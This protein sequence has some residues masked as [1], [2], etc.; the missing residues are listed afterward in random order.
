M[1]RTSPIVLALSVLALVLGAL[2][3]QA[4]VR[5]PM[6]RILAASAPDG[7]EMQGPAPDTLRGGPAFGDKE[8]AIGRPGGSNPASPARP[9]LVRPAAPLSP[10]KPATTPANPGTKTGTKTPGTKTASMPPPIAF[11]LARGE[12][13][14]CGPGCSEWIGAD[15]A[16]DASAASRLR[17]LLNR[18]G[19]HRLP[20]FF[21]SPGGS[22]EGSLAIGRLMRARG[23]TAGVA[24]TVPQGCDPKQVREEACDRLKRSG[25]DLPAQLDTATTMC[26]SA[27]VYAIVGAAVRTIGPGAKLGIHSSSFTFAGSG[28]HASTKLPRH[29]MRA[30]IEASYERLGRYF[31]EMGIDPALVAAAREIANDHIRVLSRTDIWR[32]KID[33]RGFIE[34]GWR[35]SNPPARAIHKSFVAEGAGGGAYFRDALVN[36]TCGSADRL[37]VDIAIEHASADAASE[38]G[39]RLV[40]GGAART[41]VPRRH[42]TFGS[43]KI[44]YEISSAD[45]SPTFFAAA[46]DAIAVST[47]V[48]GSSEL[49]AKSVDKF[50]D[51]AADKVADKAAGFTVTLS[52][53]GLMPALAK[54]LPLCGMSA[55]T[56]N[57]QLPPRLGP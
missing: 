18:L 4:S 16:I 3:A 53:A 46:G 49:V 2:G 11:F 39:I 14:A 8:P 38:N 23:L 13:N 34:D 47:V 33:R 44:E 42:I 19:Q 50:N 51:K 45:V 27:C 52:T 17:V 29:V 56:A 21:H 37:R 31:A 5:A 20:V 35:L 26:F 43:S 32:F 54:L 12:A 41:L 48:P 36:V 9:S 30:S 57:A 6:V 1:P 24:R 15:G 40:A 22:V 25:R 55:S 28:E 10:A 7:R